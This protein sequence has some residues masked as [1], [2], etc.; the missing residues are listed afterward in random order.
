[1]SKENIEIVRKAFDAFTSEGVESQLAFVAPDAGL[2]TA[3]EWI[4]GSE[5]RG[6][7]GMRF[8][9]SVWTDSFDDWTIESVEL[10]DAEGS[11]V[12]LIEH[13]GKVK[14]TDTSMRQR[15][16]AVCSDIR[17]QRIGRIQFFE[18]WEEALEAAAPEKSETLGQ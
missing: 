5:Y 3:P 11:V 1:V 15:M 12:A 2:Y 14:G 8:L 6:H 13:S 18:S 7:D 4:E 16:G 9:V 17:D 10:R